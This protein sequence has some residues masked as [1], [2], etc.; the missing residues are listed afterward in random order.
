MADAGAGDCGADAAQDQAGH[1][2]GEER[3]DAVD[4]RGG[5]VQRVEHLDVGHGPDL[6]PVRVDVPQPLDA[7][8]QVLV[9]VLAEGDVRPPEDGETAGEVGVFDAVVVGGGEGGGDELVVGQRG[10]GGGVADVDLAG[11][12]AAVG[13]A[14]RDVVREVGVDGGEDGDGWRDGADD[15]E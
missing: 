2:A 10:W 7:R 11:D 8:R 15:G 1:D 6:V 13:E 14:G 5:R 9:V 4:D 3:A 12:G